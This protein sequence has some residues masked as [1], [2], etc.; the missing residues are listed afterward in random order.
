VC[1]DNDQR[2]SAPVLAALRACSGIV[3][4]DNEPYRLEP[5]EEYSL[6]VHA[7]RRGLKHLQIE[8]RRD[9]VADTAGQRRWAALFGDRLEQVLD[10]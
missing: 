2:L 1:W 6:P 9:E 10:R 4:G 8:V 7:T 3:V 5:A